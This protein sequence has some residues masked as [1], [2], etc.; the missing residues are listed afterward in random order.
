M[1]KRLNKKVAIIGSL[2]LAML[3]MASIVAILRLSRSPQK[4]LADAQA[5][6]ALKEPDYKTAEKAYGMAFAY[7]KKNIELKIDILFKLSNMYISNNEWPKSA[8]CWNKV[9]NFDT[10][11]LKAR[12][13]ILDY[14]YQIATSGNW[15]TWKE[16]ESNASELIDKKLDTSPRTYRIKGQALVELVR[17]GQMTDKDK[18]IDDAMEN[19]QKAS[20]A[21]PNNVGGGCCNRL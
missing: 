4:Y 8:G 1:A 5:A 13:A 21:E 12:L 3:I 6:L 2:V 10:K 7:A 11:N 17:H 9:I 16:I 19:L 15:M 20:Q 18:A 14:N